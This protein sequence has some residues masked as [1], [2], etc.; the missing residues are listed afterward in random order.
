MELLPTDGSIL[1]FNDYKNMLRD[2]F[3]LSYVCKYHYRDKL[4]IKLNDSSALACFL[5]YD[6]DCDRYFIFNNKDYL[7]SEGYPNDSYYSIK[8]K[9]YN[10]IKELYKL[11]FLTLRDGIKSGNLKKYINTF[12]HATLKENYTN[13]SHYKKYIF[14]L[15]FKHIKKCYLNNSD[16]YVWLYDYPELAITYKNQYVDLINKHSNYFVE[17]GFYDYFNNI[18]LENEINNANNGDKN[19]IKAYL[20]HSIIK[21]VGSLYHNILFNKNTKA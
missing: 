1:K 10:K 13:T 6:I 11:A 5:K 18:D 15:F 17:N 19:D 4:A 14:N 12:N 9:I 21:K 16:M 8:S 2:K 20:Y 7:T 3:N